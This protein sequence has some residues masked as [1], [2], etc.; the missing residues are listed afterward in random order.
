MVAAQLCFTYAPVMNRL[1][2][3]AP[4]SGAS[5]LRILGVAAVVF[6]VVETEKWLRFGRG[7]GEQSLL[8]KAAG[9]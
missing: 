3:S 4:V 8:G 2:H 6:V 9:N 5:W 1:F 7:R